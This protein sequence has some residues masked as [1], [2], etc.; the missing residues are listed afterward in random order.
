MDLTPDTKQH[1]DLIAN[2]VGVAVCFIAGLVLIPKHG[3]VGAATSQFLSLLAMALVE[4][5]YL[6]RKIVD[7]KVWRIAGFTFTCLLTVC[8][9][10]WK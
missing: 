7:F 8:L 1:I 9:F 2:A 6:S 5:G 4:I 10:I 3:A